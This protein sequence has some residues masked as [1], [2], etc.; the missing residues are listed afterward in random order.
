MSISLP[1]SQHFSTFFL[2]ALFS[3]P[4]NFLATKPARSF[5]RR[6]RQKK[7]KVKLDDFNPQ[8]LAEFLTVELVAQVQFGLGGAKAVWVGKLVGVTTGLALR[9]LGDL[10]FN[11]CFNWI[12]WTKSLHGE[13]LEITNIQLKNWLFRVPGFWDF[14]DP[15][16]KSC[17]TG[18]LQLRALNMFFWMWVQKTVCF[19]TQS[20]VDLLVRKTFPGS[21]MKFMMRKRGERRCI[22][23]YWNET[24]CAWQFCWCP[25]FGHGENVTPLKWLLVTSKDR[26]IMQRSRRLNHLEVLHLFESPGSE[27]TWSDVS[28]QWVSRGSGNCGSGVGWTFFLEIFC[29]KKKRIDLF[30]IDSL[31]ISVGWIWILGDR[32]RGWLGTPRWCQKN[33]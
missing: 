2:K 6:A 3:T 9:T 5:L 12:G 14:C 29:G 27:A 10:F 30:L 11:S 23:I 17:W 15:F 19:F 22:F 13:W 28:S 24:R 1:S 8:Q 4:K 16:W 31:G 21:R 7:F 20:L 18:D 25:F 26:G 32:S 33:V